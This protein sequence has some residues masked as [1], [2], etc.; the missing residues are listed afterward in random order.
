MYSSSQDEPAAPDTEGDTQL[1]AA[2]AS[3]LTLPA[4]VAFMVFILLYFPC[5]ATFAAI[6]NES[7]KWKYAILACCYTM[8]VAWIVAFLAYHITAL[9]M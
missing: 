7:G 6:K 4:A 1:Q 3:T 8:V 9:L 2:L 5:V